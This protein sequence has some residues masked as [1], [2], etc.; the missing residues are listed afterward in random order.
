MYAVLSVTTPIFIIVLIGYLATLKNVTSKADVRALG[1]FV[2]NFALPAL[3]FR[4]LSER[5]FS[6]I[7][8]ADYLRT[9][10]LASLAVFSLVFAVVWM[11]RGGKVTAAAIQ[12]LGCS[13]S[14]SGFIGYPIAL[15]VVGPK[16]VVALAL[17]M[18][19]ENV[20]MIP[21]ALALAEGG[22]HSGRGPAAFLRLTAARLARH[23]LILGLL[24][25][26][27]FSLTGTRLPAPLLKVVDMLGATS[28]AVALFAVGGALVG[29]KVRGMVVDVGRIVTG[30]LLLHPLAVLVALQA[31]PA[32]DADLRRAMIVFASVPML[33]IYPVFGQAFDQE[34]MCA[35]ALMV[36]T[37]VSFVTVSVLLLFV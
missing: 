33:S 1:V 25:G 22:L 3:V 4:A 24:L 23:P 31:A 37:M 21:L 30:K 18:I 28:A 8:D 2:I 19:V 7:F 15:S 11:R 32:L 13:V 17:C 14:N 5:A 26:I 27:V 35:A 36:A 10:G 16:A 34:K 29:L 9:Y 6:E 12:G 20:L